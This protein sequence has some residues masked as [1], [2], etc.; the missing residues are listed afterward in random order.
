MALPQ[1]KTLKP[2]HDAIMDWLIANPQAKLGECAAAFGVTQ[3]WLSCIINS[4]IFQARYQKILGE[5]RDE[6]IL[7]LRDKLI[8]IAHQAV[9]QL[10]AHMA[11]EKVGPD[12]ALKVSDT[13]LNR[14]GYGTKAAAGVTINNVAVVAPQG[15]SR[16]EIEAARER[17]RMAQAKLVED[18]QA[19]LP[20]VGA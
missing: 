1:I 6:R 7:P 5:Y 2:K 13:I 17:Y 4:D 12:F 3:A 18:A 20:G 9:D 15:I 14:L 16:E 11:T 19:A 8:G 10:A